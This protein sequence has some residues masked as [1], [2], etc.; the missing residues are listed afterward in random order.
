MGWM[1]GDCFATGWGGQLRR[2]L[3]ASTASSARR[4]LTEFRTTGEGVDAGAKR[5]ADAMWAVEKAEV[6]GWGGIRE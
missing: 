5:N 6:G 4:S 3:T 2:C 1:L